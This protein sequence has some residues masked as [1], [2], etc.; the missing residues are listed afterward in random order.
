MKIVYNYL[1]VGTDFYLIYELYGTYDKSKVVSITVS[2]STLLLCTL[3]ER[4]FT[5]RMLKQLYIQ[6]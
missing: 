1:D 3:F 5:Y 4:I 2:V 6:R